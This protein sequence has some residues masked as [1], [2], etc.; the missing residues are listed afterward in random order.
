MSVHPSS[1][2]PSA[3]A[4][5]EPRAAEHRKSRRALSGD[6]RSRPD[7]ADH[8]GGEVAVNLE[9]VTILGV[10]V[11]NITKTEATC[12]VQALIRRS[13]GPA[14]AIYIV[15]AHTLN[16]A[17]EIPGYRAVLNS[18][19]IVFGD[20]TGIRWAARRQ[21]VRMV[22]NLVGTDL[23]P[24]VL[25]NTLAEQ[26][27]YFFL[28]AAAPV[29]ARAVD[30]VHREFPGIQIVG[31]HH[32]HVARDENEAVI[33]KINDARPDVVLVA[34]GNPTQ[35]YWIHEHRSRLR[36]GVC[37]GVGG[38]FDHWGGVLKRAPRWMRRNGLEW[39]QLLAQQPHKWR[40]YMI[41]NPKFIVRVVRQNGSREIGR[42]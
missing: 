31:F 32:G 7:G 15:N 19:D 13:D 30:H 33:A 20:G 23:M 39:L 6:G 38:L 22:D 8:S 28:G 37:I 29:V 42:T 3:D 36:A 2:Q 34:M 24:F 25:T 41:G 27:R 9:R 17:A 18:A 16:L 10:E 11:T 35:E 26:Y 40:R 1:H 5:A 12:R 21:G 4:S 14:R